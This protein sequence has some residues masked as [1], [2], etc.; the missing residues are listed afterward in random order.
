MENIKNSQ[1]DKIQWNEGKISITRFCQKLS[2]VELLL[3]LTPTSTLRENSNTAFLDFFINYAEHFTWFSDY[4]LNLCYW[5]V[6]FQFTNDK[7]F[8]S[9]VRR[10]C[11][12][13]YLHSVLHCYIVLCVDRVYHILPSF[14]KNYHQ[15]FDRFFFTGY[16]HPFLKNKGF[17]KVKSYEDWWYFTSNNQHFVFSM[18]WIFTGRC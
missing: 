13:V 14:T 18:Y 4:M 2:S 17:N 5:S 1:T 16:E 11:M 9:S 8:T 12:H 7:L 6:N 3:T 10:F 15:L